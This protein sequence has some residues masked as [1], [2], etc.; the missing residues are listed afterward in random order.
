MQTDPIKIHTTFD[1]SLRTLENSLDYSKSTNTHIIYMSSSMVY[2][3]FESNE[4]NETNDCKP[5]GIYGTLKY[6]GELMI[7]SYNQVFG[8]PIQLYVHLLYMVRDVLVD[9]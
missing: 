6:A 7:K 3:N 4:V 2:G 5:I 1:H 9:A 8:L